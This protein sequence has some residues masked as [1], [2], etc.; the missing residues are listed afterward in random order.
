MELALLA[1]AGLGYLVAVPVLVWHR[2]DLMSFRHPLWAG[3]GSRK[4]RL[5]GAVVCYLALGWPEFLMAF[6]WRVGMTRRALVVERDSM[7]E[8]RALHLGN[9]AP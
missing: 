3:Y 6:G 8:A 1:F 4:A 2:R 7:R 9:G 5:R